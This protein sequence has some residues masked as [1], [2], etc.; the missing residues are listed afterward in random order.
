MTDCRRECLTDGL[1]SGAKARFGHV[2]QKNAT[3]VRKPDCFQ[4]VFV[5]MHSKSVSDK[6][7]RIPTPGLD[8]VTQLRWVNNKQEVARAEDSPAQV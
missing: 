1:E 6:E 7:V 5:E 8:G 3:K 4:S 2:P